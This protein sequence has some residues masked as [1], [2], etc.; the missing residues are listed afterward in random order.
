M[1]PRVGL[2]FSKFQEAV[3]AWLLE[4]FGLEIACS[5]QERSHR[6]LE[7]A[8]EL[9]Q[10]CGCTRSEALQL[11]DYVYGRQ[12]GQIEQEVG[13][14]SLTLAA[15]C[16][17]HGIRLQTCSA[18][19]L[20][21]VQANIEKIRAKQA[22]KPKHSPLPQ[23]IGMTLE[24]AATLCDTI[25]SSQPREAGAYYATLTHDPQEA[26]SEW[27]GVAVFKLRQQDIDAGQMV[28]G[29]APGV[30]RVPCAVFYEPGRSNNGRL[31]TEF[32]GAKR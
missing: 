7:E 2:T 13:G 11:V 27:W 14:A 5:K 20:A 19:E 31:I 9:V 28:I 1:W 30:N 24:L 15:L 21:R 3:S 26:T 12:P 8:L 32:V 18:N 22:A 17:A 4:C 10:A 6:F 23:H 29:V 25:N 16:Y